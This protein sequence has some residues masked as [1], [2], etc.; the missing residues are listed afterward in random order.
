[1]ASVTPCHP[2][3]TVAVIL[4]TILAS[5]PKPPLQIHQK[6]KQACLLFDNK[7]FRFSETWYYKIM[8]IGNAKKQR[9]LNEKMKPEISSKTNCS[10]IYGMIRDRGKEVTEVFF[11]RH[12]G[13]ERTP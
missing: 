9:P 12:F 11:P 3:S 6:P 8:Y 2:A 1:L 4:K 7:S 5:K 10:K 13:M